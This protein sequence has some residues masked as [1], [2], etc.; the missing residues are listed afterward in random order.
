MADKGLKKLFTFAIG[1]YVLGIAISNMVKYQTTD[2]YVLNVIMGAIGG[3][4][5]YVS[6]RIES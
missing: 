3:G 4:L 2:S 6:F 1:A 5:L